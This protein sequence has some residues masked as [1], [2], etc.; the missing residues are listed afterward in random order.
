[1]RLWGNL[2]FF[3]NC[4]GAALYLILAKP[5]LAH[6]PATNVVFSAYLFASI[7]MLLTNLVANDDARIIEFLCPDCSSA[8]YVP[9]SSASTIVYWVVV[10]TALAFFLMT[11]ANTTLP[12]SVVSFY[13]CCQPLTSAIVTTLLVWA[14]NDSASS[15]EMPGWNM[16]GCIGI[17]AGLVVVIWE[18]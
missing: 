11:H 14:G 1:M 3:L 16:L 9:P 18:K 8:W 10:C 12:S 2:F 4:F 13:T 6:M 17:V 5:V 7:L 15:L